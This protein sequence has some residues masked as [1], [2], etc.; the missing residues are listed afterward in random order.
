MKQFRIGYENGQGYQFINIYT[1][2]I[3]DAHKEFCAIY[4]NAKKYIRT[5]TEIG[6]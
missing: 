3:E 5:I 6:A 4:K 2:T 1:E